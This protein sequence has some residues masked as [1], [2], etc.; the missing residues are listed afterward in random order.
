MTI[1]RNCGAYERGMKS[2]FEVHAVTLTNQVQDW[3]SDHFDAD[4][5]H[6]AECP[7]PAHKAPVSAGVR[8][9]LCHPQQA[10]S[11]VQARGT[12]RGGV[13]IDS[14]DDPI[15]VHDQPPD[16]VGVGLVRTGQ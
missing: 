4:R 1:A 15:T 2:S 10:P 5:A 11:P 14:D 8:S 16:P 9:A 6:L 12:V 13:G 3:G 7:R